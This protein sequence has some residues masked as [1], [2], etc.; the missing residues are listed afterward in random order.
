MQQISI[1]VWRNR[2]RHG[3]EQTMDETFDRVIEGVYAN[4]PDKE[5]K[6]EARTLLKQMLILPG[7]RI[8]AGAGTGKRVTL[9][10]CYASPLIQ[11]SMETEPDKPGKGIMDALKDAAITQQMGGGIGMD[12]SSIRPRG[13]LVKRTGSVSSGVL[14]FMDMWDAMCDTVKSAGSRRGA[15]M[16][17]LRIDH[18]DIEEFVDAKKEP[19]RLT[20]FNVSVLVTDRFMEALKNDDVFYLYFNVPKADGSSYRAENLSIDGWV[21]KEI[22]AR[23]LW[24]KIIGNTYVYAEPGIIFIDRVNDLNNLKYCEY[25]Y[26]TNPCAEQPLPPNGDCCLGHVN[27]AKMV[28]NPYEKDAS[29]NYNLLKDAVECMVRFLDNVLDVTEYPT[30]DQRQEAMN[31]RRIGI[32]YTGLANVF[33]QMG[34]RYGSDDAIS[35]T[36]DISFQL[37]ETAYLSSSALASE[38]GS[39]P[40][41]KEDFIH[42]SFVQKLSP[43]VE[44]SIRCYGIRNGVLLTVAPTGTVSLLA[45]NVSGGVEPVFEHSY[46]RRVRN[47]DDTFSQYD[48]YDYGAYHFQEKEL[49]KHFVTT[50]DLMIDDHLNMQAAAQ[51]WID[52]AISKTINVPTET[53]FEA[54]KDVYTKAYNLGLK[55]CTTYRFD[56]ASGR[57]VVLSTK[58]E[59]KEAKQEVSLVV[60]MQEIAEGRR[61]RIK[62][63][64]VDDAFYIHIYNHNGKPYELFVSSK[65][66]EH[67]PWIKAVT[68]LI[69]AIFR[70]EADASFIVDELKQIFDPK[71][72]V[73]MQGVYVK[74]LLALIGMKIEEH[75]KHLGLIK[76]NEK[77]VPTVEGSMCDKCNTPALHRIGGCLTC[78]NCGWSACN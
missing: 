61:Y 38:R 53:S 30:E 75:M 48:V 52:A 11:D 3:N 29:F 63:P 70:R 47:P 16:A 5:A 24:D 39:F 19:G 78:T 34:I 65:S 23:D 42:S 71:G 72:G 60:P 21:Y 73:W 50:S 76:D 74:S 18:P 77:I 45:G 68:L 40:L 67:E 33:Q 64:G 9:L 1:D 22:R 10:N 44:N 35:F 49:P 59:T 26:T 43:D 4:D 13:A 54:F 62:W 6:E 37:A 36:K 32:G 41:F 25:M 28:R 8:L 2:Y 7:G 27:L 51:E 31:K 66:V 55:G 17:T 58:K 46:S 20:N 56:P 69:T 15:Q 12:F 14:P 57:G